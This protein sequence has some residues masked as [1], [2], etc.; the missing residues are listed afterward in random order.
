MDRTSPSILAVAW[1]R[2]NIECRTE[3]GQLLLIDSN[4]RYLPF[5]V[6]FDTM[7]SAALNPYTSPVTSSKLL[8]SVCCGEDKEPDFRKATDQL[9]QFLRNLLPI[10]VLAGYQFNVVTSL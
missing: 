10:V 8:G 1:L 3:S 6:L 7:R 5:E 2:L 4:P 9:L